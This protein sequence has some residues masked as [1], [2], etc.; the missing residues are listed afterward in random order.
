MDSN[1]HEIIGVSVSFAGME[2]EGGILNI[3]AIMLTNGHITQPSGYPP[4]GF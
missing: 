3:I 1:A 2:K 4:E